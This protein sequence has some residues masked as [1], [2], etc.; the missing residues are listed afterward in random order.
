MQY[1]LT[2][3]QVG[4]IVAITEGSLDSCDPEMC[5]ELWDSS[6]D[7]ELFLSILDSLGAKEQAAAWREAFDE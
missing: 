2:E 3:E 5:D 7:I 4:A 1:E 6:E